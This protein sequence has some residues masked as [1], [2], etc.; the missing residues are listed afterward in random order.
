M[1]YGNFKDL[2]RRTVSDKV[3]RDKAFNIAK[4][5]KYDG[6]QRCLAAVVYKFFDKKS[7]SLG[8]SVRNFSSQDKSASSGAIKNILKQQL[9]EELHKSIVKK[10]KTL[11]YTHHLKIIF[12]VLIL[13]I[14][15]Y[16]IIVP[17]KDKKGI[18][19]ITNAFQTVLNEP[20]RKPNK[21]RV[22][23]GSAFY[24][25]SIKSWLQE[26]NIEMYSTHN[27]EKSVVA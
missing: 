7:A 19:I 9:A 3:L 20:E 8:W 16:T 27:E 26:N 15:K 6:Y 5:P 10:F 14:C 12:G 25:N 2:P 18:T 13:H 22:D 21:I 24:N 4:N 23:K 11:K 1:A 17:L